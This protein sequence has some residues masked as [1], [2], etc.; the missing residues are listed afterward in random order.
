[1]LNKGFFLCAKCN[2]V[3][4]LIWHYFSFLSFCC[5]QVDLQR[6]KLISTTKWI[7]LQG[8]AFRPPGKAGKMREPKGPWEGRLPFWV[9]GLIPTNDLESLNYI[10]LGEQ[11]VK[12]G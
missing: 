3:L 4:K 5:S 10:C 9:E 7:H 8:R 11:G 12:T 1:M 6:M 2:K